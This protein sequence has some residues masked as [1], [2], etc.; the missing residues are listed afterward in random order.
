M[1]PYAYFPGCTLE[2]TAREYDM[3]TRDVC[4]SLGIELHEIEDWNCC[5]ATAVT[6]IS[7]ILATALPARNLAIAE[8]KDQD[9]VAPCNACFHKLKKAAKK[10]GDDD[11]LRRNINEVLG[12]EE[13]IQY[14]GKNRIRHIIDVIVNDAGEKIAETVQRPLS[15]LKVVPYYGCLLSKAPQFM[16]FENPDRPMIMDRLLEALGAQVIDFDMKTRCCG[17]PIVMTQEEVALKLTG[18]ILKRVKELEADCIAVLCPMCHFNLDVKQAE[19]EKRL[20]MEF[21]IPVLYFTQLMGIAMG[22][23][24]KRLGLDRNMTDP[25]GIVKALA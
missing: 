6:S 12:E 4:R 9:V 23:E 14:T 21:G 17:G 7:K 20:G 19:A 10:L 11:A 18:N 15:Q 24:P 1:M 5:G 13:G 25:K 16:E 2:S 22:I 8:K 3:S